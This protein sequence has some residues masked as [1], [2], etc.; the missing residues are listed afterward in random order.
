MIYGKTSLP[1][2]GSNKLSR[3]CKKQ[4]YFGVIAFFDRVYVKPGIFPK[5]FSKVLH[6]AF[7]RRQANDYSEF[8]AFELTEVEATLK[9][10]E[11]FV[12]TI[13]QYLKNLSDETS[14]G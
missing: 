12:E 4:R 9:D 13:A 7:D 11:I 14:Q 8:S 1:N 6:L 5:D 2:S 3:R 10:A